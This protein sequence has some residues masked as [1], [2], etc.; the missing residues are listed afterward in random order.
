ML[1]YEIS[2]FGMYWYIPLHTKY[3]NFP[4]FHAW[5]EEV[6]RSIDVEVW[7]WS[8]EKRCEAV[9]VDKKKYVPVYTGTCF[10]VPSSF[11]ISDAPGWCA[12]AWKRCICCGCKT[13]DFKHNQV[14]F[15]SFSCAGGLATA[16]APPPAL[17]PTPRQLL[18]NHLRLGLPAAQLF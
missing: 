13:H 5:Y 9:L 6:C 12:R 10:Y 15:K 17:A 1:W 4:I 11:Y 7:V 2:C 18:Q 8:S 16:S 3:V 14:Y